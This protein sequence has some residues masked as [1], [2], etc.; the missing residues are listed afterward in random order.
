MKKIVKIVVYL[1]IPIFSGAYLF[2]LKSN[3]HYLIKN[4]GL[5][6]GYEVE[7]QLV[8]HDNEIVSI[9]KIPIHREARFTT[10]IHAV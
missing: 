10:T 8:L 6:E 9:R 5:I 1:S 4:S 2:N 7:N 3:I